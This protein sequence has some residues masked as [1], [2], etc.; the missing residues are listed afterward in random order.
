[1]STFSVLAIGMVTLASVAVIEGVAC[2]M[3]YLKIT[4]LLKSTI[5]LNAGCSVLLYV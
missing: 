2:G 5:I 4:L 3:G 1:V